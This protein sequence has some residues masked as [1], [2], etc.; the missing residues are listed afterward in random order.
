[1]ILGHISLRADVSEKPHFWSVCA[2]TPFFDDNEGNSISIC[3][4]SK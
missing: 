2:S 3:L 1:M 4:S